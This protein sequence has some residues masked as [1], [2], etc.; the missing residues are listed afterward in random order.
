VVSFQE[1]SR[2]I[3]NDMREQA[4]KNSAEIRDA[5]EDGK[6]RLA[7]LAAEGNALMLETK[8]S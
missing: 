4:T 5:V 3:I 7:T 1:K 2:T 8:H 6:R